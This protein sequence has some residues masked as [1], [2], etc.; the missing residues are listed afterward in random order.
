MQQLL[1]AMVG[2]E[3]AMDAFVQMFAGT[4]PPPQFFAHPSVAPLTQPAL[5]S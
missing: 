3:P 4:L 5:A 2:N 1:A